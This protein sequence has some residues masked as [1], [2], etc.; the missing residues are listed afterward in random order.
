MN[1]TLLFQ[2]ALIGFSIA[3]P[4]GVNGLICIKRTLTQGKIAGFISG[5]GAATAHGLFS[6]VA[7]LGLTYISSFLLEQEFWLRLIGGLVLCSLGAKTF[8]SKPPK[9]DVKV[10]KNSSLMN[11][12]LTT[13]LLSF[14]NPLTI[15]S[16][17]AIFSGS[18]LSSTITNNS[19]TIQMIVGVFAGSTCWWLILSS[20]VGFCRKWLT[21]G[22]LRLLNYVSGVIIAALGVV[23]ISSVRSNPFG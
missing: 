4:V 13:L 6:S 3:A 14:T 11:A 20:G 1:S 17:A 10:S 9:K 15:L 8:M 18:S 2:G 19:S 5:L 7:G 23:A 21:P 12:Y 16:F 22:R